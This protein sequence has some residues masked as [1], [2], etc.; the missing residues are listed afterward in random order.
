MRDIDFINTFFNIVYQN[1]L[2][3]MR[4]FTSSYEY[5][6][7]FCKW[8]EDHQIPCTVLKT[9]TKEN[10]MMFSK[11]M[12]AEDIDY[13][14]HN[15][16]SISM[17]ELSDQYIDQTHILYIPGFQDE[18]QFSIDFLKYQDVNFYTIKEVS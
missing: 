11:K 12:M 2:A 1:E 14:L 9:I 6:Q 3:Y 5:I 18:Q 17:Q 8:L 13:I 7:A 15:K 4:D 10:F 16:F